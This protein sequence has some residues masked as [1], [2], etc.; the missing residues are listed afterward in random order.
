MKLEKRGGGE[1]GGGGDEMM[2]MIAPN[3]LV[4]QKEGFQREDEA[5]DQRKGGP[6]G[7]STSGADTPTGPTR[8]GCRMRGTRENMDDVPLHRKGRKG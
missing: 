6:T 5:G 7:T 2:T 1:V 3:S 8:L 4:R